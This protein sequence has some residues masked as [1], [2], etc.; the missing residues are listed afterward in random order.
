MLS[1]SCQ[2]AR[3]SQVFLS[4]LLLPTNSVIVVTELL[5]SRKLQYATTRNR[6]MPP[7]IYPTTIP[8]GIS[9]VSPWSR[10]ILLYHPL[11]KILCKLIYLR[12]FSKNSKLWSWYSNL[13]DRRL[14]IALPRSAEHRTVG[15]DWAV[16]NIS[17]NTVRLYGRRFLQVKRPNQQYQSTVKLQKIKQQNTHIDTK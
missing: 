13:T 16:F 6:A 9:G 5:T 8:T 7:V 10:L 3:W 11:A 2:L 4:L 1:T 14:T 12:L 15:V 17:A